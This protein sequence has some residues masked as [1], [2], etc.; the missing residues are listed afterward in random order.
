MIFSIG[1]LP[2]YKNYYCK[3]QALYTDV[4]RMRL[5]CAM[6]IVCFIL[7][8]QN[9][10]AKAMLHDCFKLVV[11]GGLLASNCIRVHSIKI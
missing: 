2:V 1:L 11:H 3:L 10:S 6:F 5:K 7:K 9:V 8:V 4:V